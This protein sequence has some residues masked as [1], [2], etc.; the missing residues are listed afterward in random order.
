M[1]H[2][3]V[4]NLILVL[5][6]FFLMLASTLIAWKST[7]P[8]RRLW[9]VIQ[10]MSL[11]A[12]MA[13]LLSLGW[14]LLLTQQSISSGLQMPPGLATGLTAA[15]LALLI[16]SL[17][18]VIAGFSARYLEGEAGQA[19]Y[20]GA[21]T[22]VLAA[23]QLLVLADHWLILIAAWVGV[24]VALHRLLCFYA[25]RPF[26][27]LAA[28]KK[29]LADR[30]ADILLLLAAGLATQ[31]VGSASISALLQHVELHGAD[32]RL[33]ICAVLLVLAV[34]IRSAMLPVHGWL[35][36]VMEAPTPV[37]ALLHAGV[38]NLGGY[39]LIRFA[40]LLESAA[41]ARY[42]LVLLGLSSALMAGFVMLTRISIKVR[43]AWSTLAQ[44]GFMLLECGLGL[45]QLAVLHLIGHSLYKAHAFLSSGD[46][47]RQARLSDLRGAGRAAI[48]SMV[49][50]PMLTAALVLGLSQS[51]NVNHVTTWPWW[52]S[53]LLALAWAPMLWIRADVS[54]FTAIGYRCLSGCLLVGLL[55]CVAFA[56]HALPLGVGMQPHDGAGM[57]ALAVMLLMYAGTAALQIPVCSAY[58]EP[59][60][61][62][63]YAGFYLDEAYT[64]LV[65]RLWP[66]RLPLARQLPMAPAGAPVAATQS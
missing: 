62:Q 10:A 56:L 40:P 6:P 36:Q 38:V 63:S 11:L 25:N 65:L 39:V 33:H 26:A 14:Q 17:G 8:A 66:V 22:G 59:L 64:R 29:F 34:A 49:L 44:M 24:S 35:I 47:V 37:S 30:L 9:S 20:A 43:L 57:F 23:V 55:M 21:L 4:L 45:Y 58:L 32:S 12:S 61:R 2:L 41:P 48:W 54:G 46:T 50:A 19:R 52:W 7:C 13:A 1:F 16:Q 31:S 60:R 42:L 51:L 18:S 53:L 15:W 28:H 3:H 27:T 5:S